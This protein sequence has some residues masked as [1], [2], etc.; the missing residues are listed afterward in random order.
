MSGDDPR[1]PFDVTVEPAP[2]GDVVDAE[3][4]EA[5]KRAREAALASTYDPTR[6]HAGKTED[7]LIAEREADARLIGD[8]VIVTGV[9]IALHEAGA[10]DPES[11]DLAPTESNDGE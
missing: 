3:E 7:E 1:A 9:A 11:D 2:Q 10:D 6:A 8:V 5:S 4:D